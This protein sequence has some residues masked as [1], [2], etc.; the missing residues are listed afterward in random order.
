MGD[1]ADG[2]HL[3][4]AWREARLLNADRALGVCMQCGR[5]E[6]LESRG[7]QLDFAPALLNQT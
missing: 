5:N 3:G 7:N 4:T 2:N 6:G 1:P